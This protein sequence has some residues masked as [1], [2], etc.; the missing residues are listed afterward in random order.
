MLSA[1]EH[2][3][4]HDSRGGSASHD[5]LDPGSTVTAFLTELESSD[6]GH[7]MSTRMS[8][9]ELLQMCKQLRSEREGLTEELETLGKHEEV[10]KNLKM[11]LFLET[12][13]KRDTKRR[14][15]PTALQPSS[16]IA[17]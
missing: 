2:G 1:R 10:I 4:S 14:R 8:N 15:Q 3:G 11:P 12:Q 13:T 6:C 9:E 16:L 17:K 5:G 7:T